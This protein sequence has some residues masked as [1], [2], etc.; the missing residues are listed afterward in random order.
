MVAVGVYVCVKI[1]YSVKFLKFHRFCGK[2]KKIVVVL[3]HT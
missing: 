2:N 3:S 1:I